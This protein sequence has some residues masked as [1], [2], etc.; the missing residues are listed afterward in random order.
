[1][2]EKITFRLWHTWSRLLAMV[3][4]VSIVVAVIPIPA[5]SAAETGNSGYQ[6]EINETMSSAG[7]IHPGVGLT[8]SILETTREE[9]QAKKEP[10]YS[11]FEAMSLSSTASKTVVS[12]NQS[13]TDPTKPASVEFNSQSFNSKFISDGLKAY[14]QA[15]MYYFTGDETY[16]ANAMQIIRIWSQMDP[17]KYVYFT[18]SHIH[19]GIPLNRMV[20]AAEILRYTSSPTPSLEW[21]ENDTTAFTNNLITPVTETFLH[22]NNYFM[23]QHNYPILGAMAGYIFT[24]N[25]ERYDEAVEWW[26]VNKTAVDQGI[27]GS[28]KQLFRLIDTN[29]LTG[30]KLAEP[31]VQHIEMGRDQAHGGGDLT[32][33][34]ITTRMLHAQGTK[35]DPV[36]GTVSTKADAVD[37]MEF[38]NDRII[39]AA[40]YFWQY[41][42]GYD[43]PWVPVAYSYTPDGTIKDTYNRFSSQY[44]GRFLTANFWDFYS[45]YTYSKGID[46]AKKA[47][48]YYEA[49]TKKPFLNWE[50]VDGG[51]DFWLYLPKEAEADAEKFLPKQQTNANLNEVEIR[52]TA[53]DSNTA[54]IQEGDTT[55]IRF[56]A[57]ETGAKIALLS[58]ATSSKTIGFKIRSNGTAK[59]DMVTGINDTL[60]LPDTEGQWRYVTYTMNQFQNLGDFLYL[61]VKAPSGTTVD[62]DHIKLD[63]GTQLTPPSFKTGNTDTNVFSYVGAP[64]RIDFSATDAS[65]SDVVL[66][67][68]SNLPQN[69]ALDASTGAFSWQPA[70]AGT[71]SFVVTA[72][73]GTTV[74]A[75][76]VS[77][78]V[79]EDRTAAVQATIAPYNSDTDYIAASLAQYKAAYNDTVNQIDGATDE[80]FNQQLLN[81]RKATE[82]LQLVTPLLVSDGSLDYSEMVSSAMG[83]NTILLV[84]NDNDT[85]A[86]F[87]SGS[88]PSQVL[89]FGA[90][91]KIS[92]NAFGV[93]SRMNFIDRGAG[94]AIY[95]SNDNENWTR[96]TPGETAF[97]SEMSIIAVDDAY[98]D[99]PFRY[100]KIQMIHPQPD[101]IHNS[102]QNI[103]ELGEFRIYGVRYEIGNKLE[104][105]SFSSTQGLK[106]R[107]IQGDTAKLTIRTKEAIQNM[108]VMIQGQNAVV[109]TQ[110]NVNWTAAA[111]L[112]KG[113]AT[114]IVKFTVDYQKSDGTKGDTVY[115]TTDNSKLFFADES[116]V[117][118]NVTS[119]TSLMDS[120]TNRTAAQTLQQTSYL[121]DN[122][123]AFSDFR[124][125]GAGAGNGA[126][127]TFDFK[128]GNQVSISSME[129]LAR[130][131]SSY[132]RIA[133]TV[134]QGSNDNVTWKTITNV[135]ASTLDWQTLVGNDS[136]SLYRYIRIYNPNAWFGNMAEVRFH[137]TVV[138]PLHELLDQA[139]A[140]DREIYTADSL[141]VLDTAVSVGLEVLVN[142]NATQADL[143]NVI[144]K[145]K[146]AL[147]GLQYIP[148]MPVIQGLANQTVI[149]GNKLAFQVQAVNAG[150]DI[151][152]GAENL[153]SGASFDAKTRTF[154]WTPAIGQGGI[155]N[156]TFNAAAGQLSSSKTIKI[157][158]IGQPVAGTVGSV[159]GTAGQ[160]LTYQVPVTDP[161]GEPLVYGAD[162]MPPGA[163][164]NALTGTMSWTP[165][166][167]DYGDHT[168]TFTVHNGSFSINVTVNFNVKLNIMPAID[169]TKGS[170]Y[171]YKNEITRINE[172]MDKQGADK[173]TLAHE[174][175]T[176]E[177]GLVRVPLALYSFESVMSNTY[178]TTAAKS[179]GTPVYVPGKLGQAISLNG[180][181][182]DYLQLP[183][184][185][186]FANYNELTIATWV[187]WKGG[188]QW[189]RIFDFGNDTNQ[190]LFLSPRS[191]NNTLRFA[192]K[193]GGAEQIV[194]TS[195]LAANQWVHVAVTLGNGTA[196]LYVNGAL[197]ATASVSI[198]PSDFKPAINYIGKS[199]FADPMFNGLLDELAIYDHVLSAD[200]IQGVMNTSAQ[201]VDKSLL[202][203]MLGQANVVETAR[204]TPASVA[205]LQEAVNE[206]RQVQ[207][208][209]NIGQQQVDTAADAIKT[210]L[211]GLEEM[212][213][214]LTGPASVIG[215]QSL[216]LTYSLMNVQTSVYAKEA[217]FRFDPAVLQFVDMESL[218]QRFTVVASTYGEGT[219]KVIEAGLN[220]SVTGSMNL[221]KLHFMTTAA[222]QTVTSSVYMSDIVIADQNGLETR[223]YIGPAYKVEIVKVDKS[224]LYSMIE[225]ANAL[226]EGD[227]KPSTWNLLAAKRIQAESVYDDPYATQSEVNASV[228]VLQ[229]AINQLQPR[230]DW[231][232]LS[233]KITE[234][235]SLISTA[236]Q[237]GRI[238]AFWGQYPQSAVDALKAT[239]AEAKNM[240]SNAEAS[241]AEVDLESEKL[242][243]E[244]EKLLTTVNTTARIGDLARM[245]AHYGETS[246]SSSNWYAVSMYDF[247]NDGELS[248]IDLSAMALLI[249]E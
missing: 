218:E 204:Y 87:A 193:N 27:N 111:V 60:T 98:K 242:S 182:S 92:A 176:A 96:L 48:H 217:T 212:G 100:I 67:D 104:T 115:A 74:A 156:T 85:F 49:F 232:T 228:T 235:E 23:N 168:V 203:T 148:G 18:D 46:L 117:I 147:S 128:K 181:T 81:L 225:S 43:T 243:A 66:Y 21:T 33:A 237:A 58:G 248:I 132:T 25:K 13:A 2:Q 120:T 14:T 70:G 140:T 89:D 42:L 233:G 194:Q 12:S 7:F 36:E 24:D 114:G 34:A 97:N 221:L 126:Y 19:T 40:D 229:T 153:P 76:N 185:H 3:V 163:V 219:I 106:G 20:M 164:L 57:K 38:L 170:Y 112:N 186:P 31:V 211:E 188:D 142:N 44:K 56:N 119:I 187:N 150:S 37:P 79:S 32:N 130:Q 167:A 166:Q 190:Y 125:G 9:I 145:L 135:A 205:I 171:L 122:T 174:I 73:D 84:D 152:Y 199:Q 160:T 195:Q 215:G 45:Y 154:E 249:L 71:Y 75:K 246:A 50:N 143:D 109:T 110:D 197:A 240:A 247:N 116:D 162:L 173:I 161:S 69:A 179:A 216:D 80:V 196:Q 192:I 53:L 17:T 35:L 39:T 68:S 157:K 41:M 102:V 241:Q 61:T 65:S 118:K 22:G 47:P 15:L 155:Y 214:R 95:G 83:N 227:Y 191:G 202:S 78:V 108:K 86:G 88:N 113:T 136:S 103:L 178:G 137:G 209:P 144:Q 172:E 28:I 64:V 224:V 62:I 127:I 175:E 72:S 63:A 54:K 201:W 6:V 51:D 26:S 94:I 30:E 4:S 165:T 105:V 121:F 10:W 90:D 52:Y 82:N 101:I 129:I 245:S 169:Y 77:I 91:F 1:M 231:T 149:A 29:D 139:L 234:A 158:V 177:K 230:A 138:S 189:Q 239:I 133:G 220:G 222:E 226:L 55:F 141:Q 207:S 131:D 223:L 200:E 93:Q 99:K 238:G 244:L 134:V 210:A 183:S 208:N 146:A 16:R 151:S 198:K 236:T 206:A 124:N 5:T 180:G 59:L 184:K 213:V 8:K 159:E 107:L 11:Y 123:E